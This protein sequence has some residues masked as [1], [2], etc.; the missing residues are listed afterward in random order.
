VF[1]SSCDVR[2]CKG[3][4]GTGALLNDASSAA[5]SYLAPLVAHGPALDGNPVSVEGK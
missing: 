5:D 4:L 2:V 1:L 3:L